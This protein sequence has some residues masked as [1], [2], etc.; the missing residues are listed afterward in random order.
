[1]K[2]A[3]TLRRNPLQM[4]FSLITSSFHIAPTLFFVQKRRSM[5]RCALRK[6]TTRKSRSFSLW[7]CYILVRLCIIWTRLRLTARHNEATLRDIQ[8]KTEG[9]RENSRFYPTNIL[10]SFQTICRHVD[11]ATLLLPFPSTLY[12]L[13]PIIRF[14]GWTSGMDRA[15]V[16]FTSPSPRQHFNCRTNFVV[17]LTLWLTILRENFRSFFFFK[18]ESENYFILDWKLF[19]R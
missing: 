2:K 4:W 13:F 19:D 5:K 7:L 10:I 16:P 1:M 3:H 18:R 6:V 8:I 9:E 14:P 17:R 15:L 11:D 12:G